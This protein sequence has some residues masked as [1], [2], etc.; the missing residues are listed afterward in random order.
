MKEVIKIKSHWDEKWALIQTKEETKKCTYYI[1]NYGRIKS[2]HKTT[3]SEKIIK[4]SLMKHGYRQLCLR[5][6]N[7]V[8]QNMYVHRLVGETFIKQK[9]K[10]HEFLVHVDR[11]REN[12]YHKNLQWLNREELNK[13]W[14]DLEIYK[15]IDYTHR[16]TNKM[17]ESKVILLKKRLKKG[18]TKIKLLAKQFDISVTQV[19]RIESGENWGNV[20]I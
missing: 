17:T 5:L 20:K 11:N 7:N 15:N 13:R 19:K 3:G 16:S 8:R 1:S 2:V 12:N 14:K 10:A 18:K 9:S 6:Q 4:G